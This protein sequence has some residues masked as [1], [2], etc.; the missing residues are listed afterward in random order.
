MSLISIGLSGLTAAQTA[1]STTGN[2]I[3]NVNTDGYSRQTVSQVAS[4]SVSI[5]VAYVGTGTTVADVRRIYSQYLSNQLNSSTALDAEAQT[6]YTSISTV[7]SILADSTTGISSALSS[8]F[9]ALQTASATPTDSSARA[10]LLTSASSLAERFNSIYS[11]LQDQNS[12]VNQQLA[13]SANQVN[14]LASQIASYNQAIV[15]ATASGA[16]PNDLLDAREAAVKELSSLVGVSVVEQDGAYNVYLGSGQPLVVGTSVSTLSA[17]A[18]EEDPSRYSLT[19]T[20]PGGTSVDVTNSVSGGSI[21][22]LIRYRDEVLD[23]SLNELGRLALVVSDA[24]DSQLAQGLD[25][26]GEFGSLLFANINSADL[27]SQRSIGQDGNSDSSA[28]LDVTISDS[29]ALS[30]SDYEVTFISATEYSVKR[31]SDNTD[32]G[33]YS[34]D[35]DPPAEIDGFT[36]SLGSG[37]VAAGDSFTVMPTRNAAGTISV[38]MTDSDDIALASPLTVSASDSNYGS[39]ILG[40][41]TLTTELDIYDSTASSDLASSI[42]SSLP[43]KLIFDAAASDGTQGY[44]VYDS[45]GNSIGTGSIIPGQSNTLSISVDASSDFT[46]ELTLSGSPASGDSFTVS[47]NSDG[48]SDNTNALALLALQTSASVG[49]SSMTDAYASLV[50]TVGAMTSQAELDATATATILSI[51]EENYS[52]MSGVNLDEEAADLIMFQ[53]YYTASAKVIEIAQTIFNTLIQSF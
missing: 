43:V 48:Q 36:L 38:V 19:L 22:G 2:N 16:T 30:T 47:F 29:S 7:D 8:F 45:S 21:T 40:T 31:L 25:L 42:E 23:T 17:S 9:D 39:G 50:E 18:S 44:T 24:I 27:I 3:S 11:Q 13:A 5:G 49:S 41:V 32:M 37:S 46:F 20:L 33:T 51:A 26:D 12:Y 10:L 53:Q 35:D 15:A 1:L 52:S 4:A 6:Y 28:N 34:L 14:T